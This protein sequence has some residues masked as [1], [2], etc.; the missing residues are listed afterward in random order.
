MQYLPHLPYAALSSLLDFL[1]AVPPPPGALFARDRRMDDP[2][3]E[4]CAPTVLALSGVEIFDA[5]RPLK[6]LRYLSFDHPWEKPRRNI[7]F[8]SPDGRTVRT[9]RD[10]DFD[11]L[12]ESRY[13]PTL[14]QQM[15]ALIRADVAAVTPMYHRRFFQVAKAHPSLR[16]VQH[17]ATLELDWLWFF[18]RD[19][20]R[21]DGKLLRMRHMPTIHAELSGIRVGAARGRLLTRE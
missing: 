12:I 8:L 21:D 9:Q 2:V 3:F 19:G 5:L 16:V 17:G 4:P 10:G 18:E 6:H 20:D 15:E 11:R 14:E 13:G 1:S 7:T